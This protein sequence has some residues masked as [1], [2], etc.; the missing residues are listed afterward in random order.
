MS[1]N[2]ANRVGRYDLITPMLPCKDEILAKF[3]KIL[4][5]GNFILGEEVRLLEEE[6]AAACGV[7]DAVGVASGSSALF[8]SVETKSATTLTV[9]PGRSSVASPAELR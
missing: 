9:C 1:E 5:S 6:L 3:E 7:P 8:A 4:M 2:S